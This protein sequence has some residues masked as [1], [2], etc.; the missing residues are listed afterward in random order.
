MYGYV[1]KYIALLIANELK[2]EIAMFYEV[3]IFDPNEMLKEVI[4]SHDL[5]KR[6]WALFNRDEESRAFNSHPAENI[7]SRRV[8]HNRDVDSF[9]ANGDLL[10]FTAS[11]PLDG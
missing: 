8:K 2:G 11:M 10:E 6:H 3:R 9:I 1:E 7:P 5:E 4:S